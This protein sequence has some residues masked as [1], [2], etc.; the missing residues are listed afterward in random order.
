VTLKTDV[1]HSSEMPKSVS[2]PTRAHK[3]VEYYV[4]HSLHFLN[5]DHNHN[6]YLQI[7]FFCLVTQCSFVNVYRHVR[8]TNSLH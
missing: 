2:K 8:G 7:V 4:T 3:P 6:I 5:V 1:E